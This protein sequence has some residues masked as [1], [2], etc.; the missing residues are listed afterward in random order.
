MGVDG[1]SMIEML[2]IPGVFYWNLDKVTME[3]MNGG[4]IEDFMTLELNHGSQT[5]LNKYDRGGK[6][7]LST[8]KFV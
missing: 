2:M 3:R 6:I 4:L 7:F 8:S 5:S 1:L